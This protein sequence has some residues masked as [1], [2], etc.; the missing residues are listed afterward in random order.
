MYIHSIYT[1]VVLLLVVV[2]AGAVDKNKALHGTTNT[3]LCCFDNARIE[4]V[5]TD[6][7]PPESVIVYYDFRENGSINPSLQ[8]V[9]FW[10]S[11]S[12]YHLQPRQVLW[13]TSLFFAES[14][15]AHLMREVRVTLDLECVN[16]NDSWMQ[17]L[18]QDLMV[19]PH[20]HACLTY[21]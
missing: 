12:S 9:W 5:S 7:E 14:S 16:A 20:Q 15:E 2:C 21:M 4:R 3:C 10:T 6:N 13:Y 1:S 17:E 19:R 11:S 8:K 18:T